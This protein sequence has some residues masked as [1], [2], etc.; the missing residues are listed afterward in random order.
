MVD[1]GLNGCNMANAFYDQGILSYF[2]SVFSDDRCVG[3]RDEWISCK[4]V[5][6]IFVYKSCEFA[7]FIT[8]F[9]SIFQT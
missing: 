1:N 9:K 7:T 5:V 2:T 6:T 4:G 8:Q 3:F